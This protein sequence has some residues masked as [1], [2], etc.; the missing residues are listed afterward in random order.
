MKL[1]SKIS[2][3]NLILPK[4]IKIWYFVLVFFL[5]LALIF[6]LVGI[7]SLV[8]LSESFLDK[9]SKIDLLIQLR[10]NFKFLS[11]LSDFQI[12]LGFTSISIICSNIVLLV[13]TYLNAKLAFSAERIIKAKIYDYFMK[14]KYSNFFAT[15]ESSFI[16]IITNETQ[17][18][19]SQVLLPMA[20]IISRSIIIFGIIFF[21]LYLRPLET[22]SIFSFILFFYLFY[23]LL[24]KERIKKNNLTLTHQNKNLLR[25]TKNIFNS[26]REIKVYSF[27]KY[28]FS[29]IS[30]T[31]KKIQKIR[32]F[33][34]FFANSPRYYMEILI[35]II[36]LI[37]F[38]IN[39][40]NF[41]AEENF[42]L[43]AVFG[44]SFFKIIPSIQGLFSQYMVLKSNI[45]AVDEIYSKTH[46][47]NLNLN[48]KSKNS[49]SKNL[50][51]KNF[52]MK[53]IQFD[54]KDKKVFKDLN[55]SFNAGEKIGLIGESGIGKSTFLNIFSGL[56]P[57]IK[58]N[59]YING[60]EIEQ[61][62]L[63]HILKSRLAIVPQTALMMQASIKENIIMGNTY[64]KDKFEKIISLVGLQKLINSL[65]DKSETLVHSSNLNFSGGQIQRMAFARALYFEPSIL[66]IDEGFNQLDK[67]SENEI[68]NKLNLI[69]GLTII[70]VYHKMYNQRVFDK[71]Y[72]IE[73]NQLTK[74]NIIEQQ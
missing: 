73:N 42:S 43:I 72:K 16:S 23:F 14:E 74:A 9:N 24:L 35:F 63:L 59:F 44:Y 57:P 20:E 33:T 71:I 46:S 69:K 15:N 41:S 7:G 52:E 28:F 34:N 49:F 66:L 18:F 27:E 48:K 67:L 61:N 58:G 30:E 3:I 11:E 12:L 51:I 25:I 53:N 31:T 39:S 1:Q 21:L 65:D 70:V 22:I 55:F 38:T 68:I 13:T 62:E 36:V 8:P 29:Q 50:I 4:K 47:M 45:A 64:D 2:K 40:K 37:F 5:F 32:F 17:R 6:Q 56:L 26:F 10:G 60:N 19:T 54:F